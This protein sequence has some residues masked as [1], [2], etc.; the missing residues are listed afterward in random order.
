MSDHQPT[1]LDLNMMALAINEARRAIEA[2]KAGVA[3]LL[4]WRDEVIVLGHNLYQ[5]TG[6]MTAHGEMVVLR[7]AA[8]FFSS[9]ST[10][11]KA[12]LT[13]YVT[14]EPCLMCPLAISFVGIKRVV[15]AA[16]AED[17]NEEEMLARDLTAE[18]L[19]PLLTR[20]PL[21]LVPGVLRAE[22][23]ELLARMGKLRVSAS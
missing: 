18:R 13:I 6:D 20:G 21:E 15:Y 8:V 3:A 11:E 5:E 2:G 4:C 16:L 1:S 10:E 22:G 23:R 9:L 19:N 17:A 14:L 7:A 12:H